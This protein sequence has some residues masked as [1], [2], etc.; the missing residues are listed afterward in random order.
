MVAEVDIPTSTDRLVCV[1]VTFNRADKLLHSLTMTLKQNVDYIIV[2]DNA[3]TDHTQSVLRDLQLIDKRLII[4][5]QSINR[6]GSWGFAYGMRKADSI[7]GGKGWLLLFDDDSWPESNC[8]QRFRSRIKSYREQEIA[9]VASSVFASNGIAVE[10]N[11]PILN[12]FARPFDVLRSTL[13]HA[14]SL[15]DLYHVPYKLLTSPGNIINVDAISFVGLFI[16]LDSVPL[17]LGRYP[18]G[19]LFIYSDD[20]S[21]TLNLSRMGCRAVLDTDLIF[22]HDTCA[23]GASTRWLKPTWKYY[24][25]IR[26]SFI[27]NR[28]LSG[29]LYYLLCIATFTVHFA[30]GVLALVLTADMSVLRMVM[31]G[32]KDGANS[33]FSRS[34]NTI[35]L[36]SLKRNS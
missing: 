20:T 12:L 26:N 16:R 33:N 15:R 7:L 3:S 4:D 24:Y 9:L 21:Y 29:R 10:A 2:I 28:L 32:F 17:G 30:K 5:R 14:R 6:G 34:H 27:V 19:A 23:G 31:L 18:R 25:V 36:L 35:K 13:P 8:I 1:V 11:R 22:R